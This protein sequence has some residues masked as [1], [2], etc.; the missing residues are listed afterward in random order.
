MVKLVV[1]YTDMKMLAITYEK[2]KII[3]M[4]AIGLSNESAISGRYLRNR[5]PMHIFPTLIVSL[6]KK[7][8]KV[9]IPFVIMKLPECL[10]AKAKAAIADEQKLL[11]VRA[12]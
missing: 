9:P 11:P 12:T 7:Q 5:Y 4:G 3:T 2:A 8:I 10:R 1:E 6:P